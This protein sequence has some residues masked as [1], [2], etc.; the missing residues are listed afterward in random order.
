MPK[1][2][3][4][5]SDHPL[6]LLRAIIGVSQ[7]KFAEV[8]G[9]SLAT[10]SSAESGRRRAIEELSESQRSQL[11]SS[12]GAI[13]DEPGR[14]W[15]FD[16]GGFSG[17]R[18]PYLREHYETFRQELK[19]EAHDRDL[20]VYYM[21]LRFSRFC[22]ELPDAGFNAFFWQMEQQFEKWSQELNVDQGIELEL[23]PLWDPELGRTIGYKKFPYH[24]L[25]GEEELF[26]KMI[27]AARKEKQRMRE[28]LFPRRFSVVRPEPDQPKSKKIKG[29]KATTPR[30][31][32]AT[33]PAA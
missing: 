7:E 25:E 9:F 5:R 32:S 28:L 2:D 33:Q 1:I 30:V 10:I 15:L 4:S 12:L 8:V 20:I 16:P 19:R 27:E 29:K 3:P 6:K 17:R 26:A 11:K 24:V 14:R 23:E 31:I 22:R 18:M 13:W 21:V